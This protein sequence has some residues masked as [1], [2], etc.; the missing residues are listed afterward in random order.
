L[1]ASIEG[2][3]GEPRAKYIHTVERGLWNK[4]TNLNN[5]K[6]WAN[7]PL[8]INKGADWYAK[9]G[10]AKSKGTGIFSL[11]GKVNNT[12]LIEIPMGTPLKQI[13]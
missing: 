7:V 4:P 1:I 3:M 8:I 5:V 11:V 10:T 13:I 6:T 2:K 9:I 12:G